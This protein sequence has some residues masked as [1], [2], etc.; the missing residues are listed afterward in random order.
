MRTLTWLWGYPFGKLVRVKSWLPTFD[1]CGCPHN[2]RQWGI[3][4][5]T[6]LL[7]YPGHRR[8]E[9]PIWNFVWLQNRL[10]Y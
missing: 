8:T 10:G 9:T 1:R 3:G 7:D 4:W 2:W 5:P 6:M